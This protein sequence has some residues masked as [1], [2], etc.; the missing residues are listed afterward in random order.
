MLEGHIIPILHLNMDWIDQSLPLCVQ[1]FELGWE[2]ACV[3]KGKNPT[4]MGSH[5]G[6]IDFH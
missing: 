1:V 6:K 5:S 4:I 3:Y 2:K